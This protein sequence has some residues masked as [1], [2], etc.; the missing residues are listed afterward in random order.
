MKPIFTIKFISGNVAP[1]TVEFTDK[2]T[3]LDERITLFDFGDG[4]IF[5]WDTPDQTV[6]QHIYKLAGT[7][8]AKAWHNSDM[9]DITVIEILAIPTPTPPTSLWSAFIAWLKKLF[10]IV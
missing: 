4:H 8:R 10:G 1:A 2:F 5:T 3:T 9:S 7:F 6:A